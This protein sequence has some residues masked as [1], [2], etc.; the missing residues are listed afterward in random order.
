MINAAMEIQAEFAQR[1]REVYPEKGQAWLDRLP[2][3]IR[4]LEER[5]AIRVAEP[6]PGLT[7]NYVA[8]ATRRDG[9]V[10]VLKLGVPNPELRSEAATLRLDGGR[11][12]ARLLEADEQVAALLLERVI[13]GT[14]LVE[15]ADDDEATRVAA[16]VMKRIWRRAPD[17][18]S[19]PTVGDW[20][21]GM[22]RLRARFNGATGPFDRELVEEAE[23]LYSQLLPTMSEPVVLH[24]DLHHM[25]ILRGESD[26]LAI[27]PKG[28]VGEPVYEVGALL[29][30]PFPEIL[31]WPNAKDTFRR[32]VGILSEEL[33]FDPR[34]IRDWAVAQ[35]VLS[36]WWSYE[37]HGPSTRLG[38]WLRLVK[39]QSQV[40]F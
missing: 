30:N 9:A 22:A 21:R 4:E 31:S 32:R 24:G 40:M 5:W 27:D 6:F 12:Y 8:P 23:R 26:W 36:A 15:L 1:M 16:S 7:Y 14:A 25:N 37:D 38:S 17:G 2:E 35:G 3:K 20:A 34:R 29:R 18:S 33:G 13:P 11:G 39:T 19:F 28:V 10:A